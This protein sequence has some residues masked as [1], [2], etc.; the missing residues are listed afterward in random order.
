M[1]TAAALVPIKGFHVGKSRLGDECL[2]RARASG[3]R[4]M[5]ASGDPGAEPLPFG[6][7]AHLLPAHALDG[8]AGESFDPAVFARL[9]ETARTVLRPTRQ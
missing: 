2:D 6:A 4:V 9:L 5:R 3:R 8:L 1:P 7:V